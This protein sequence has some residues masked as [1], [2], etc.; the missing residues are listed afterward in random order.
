MI[1]S[2]EDEKQAGIIFVNPTP[3]LF[4]LSEGVLLF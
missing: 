1:L 4:S 3:S 2:S